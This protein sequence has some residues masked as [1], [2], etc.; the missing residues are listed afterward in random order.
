MGLSQKD[1][2]KA[3]EYASA[4]AEKNYFM[5]EESLMNDESDEELRDWITDI[6]VLIQ[7]W[8]GGAGNLMRNDGTGSRR[9]V[10]RFRN[11]LE[12]QVIC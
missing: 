12:G 5:S 4:E 1:V 10:C 3:E 9:L 7:K 11:G 2:K 8:L 6:G